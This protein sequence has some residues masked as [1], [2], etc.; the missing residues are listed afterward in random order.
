[1][2]ALLDEYGR[3]LDPDKPPVAGAG[4]GVS[5]ETLFGQDAARFD[6]AITWQADSK[7]VRIEIEGPS[8]STT[9]DYDVANR[10]VTERWD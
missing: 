9:I 1:M 5:I 6:Q 4:S 2:R 3:Q 8:R 10:K 7:R